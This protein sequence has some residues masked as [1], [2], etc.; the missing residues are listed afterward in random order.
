MIGSIQQAVVPHDR[1]QIELKLDYELLD[2]PNTHYRVE[3][4]IFV[5]RTL[6]ITRNNYTKRDFYRDIQNYIRLKT[7]TLILRDFCES[8][9]S[10]LR[11]IR[12]IIEQTGWVT[13]PNAIEP[14]IEQCK[15]LASTLKSAIRE[16]IDHLRRQLELAT[17]EASHQLLIENLVKE[18]LVETEKISH[19]YHT[20]FAEFSLPLWQIA[21]PYLKDSPNQELE[22]Q[23]IARIQA[24]TTY[25]E[26]RD[27]PSIL[28]EES[29]NEEYQ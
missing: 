12:G 21:E 29:D 27:Y 19:N 25:R 6:S 10:P 11:T 17:T 20:L 13:D 14:L 15:L 24:E 7:P 18:F 3:T 4:Y 23:F 28:R 2:S 26:G 22:Q 16:H 9:H 5:P 8:Q 1:Y